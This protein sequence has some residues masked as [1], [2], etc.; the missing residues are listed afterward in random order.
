MERPALVLIDV[1]KGFNDVRWGARNNPEAE[2]NIGDLLAKFRSRAL[3]V[4]HVQH[5]SK[6]LDS[7]LRPDSPGVEF[8]DGLGPAKNEPVFQK[9]VNSAFI[10]TDLQTYL[11]SQSIVSVV[12]VGFTTDHCVSTSVRMAANLGFQATVVSDATATFERRMGERLF[13]AQVM[14]ETSLASLNGEF[15]IVLSTEALLS[16][17]R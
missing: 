9:C 1:Q 17:L 15:A 5:L 3:P 10:G 7:P 16:Q 12:V 2:R 11:H 13:P 8:M 4:I 14:H 6:E